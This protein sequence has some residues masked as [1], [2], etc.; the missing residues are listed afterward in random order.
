MVGFNAVL[1]HTMMRRAVSVAATSDERAEAQQ[2]VADVLSAHPGTVLELSESAL[3]D[4]MVCTCVDPAHAAVAAAAVARKGPYSREYLISGFLTRTDLSLS[5]VEPFLASRAASVLSAESDRRDVLRLLYANIDPV[6]ASVEALKVLAVNVAAPPG[7]RVRATAQLLTGPVQSPTSERNA[8][9]ALRN[10]PVLQQPVFSVLFQPAK[11]LLRLF[12]AG[13]GSWSELSSAQLDR[14]VDAFEQVVQTGEGPAPWLECSMELLLHPNL[15]VSSGRRIVAAV[16]ATGS[17]F[18]TSKKMQL[19][20][21]ELSG[22][23]EF[24]EAPNRASALIGRDPEAFEASLR[25]AS[26]FRSEEWW[27]RILGVVPHADVMEVLNDPDTSP[28]QRRRLVHY[29]AQYASLAV[30]SPELLVMLPVGM[31]R[32][33]RSRGPVP[34]SFDAV[35]ADLLVFRLGPDPAAWRMFADLAEVAVEDVTVGDVL[36]LTA[37]LET[38]Q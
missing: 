11:E 31:F 35:F 2:L 8:L 6:T 25:V 16:A 5:D 22:T 14:L 37:S 17:T 34:H 10:C 21:N 13:P 36:D 15:P 29:L 28:Q 30:C 32:R 38:G 12:A 1:A 26:G 24:L 33:W 23:V 20:L 18:P 4:F 9:H 7:V 19:W 3:T 27:V